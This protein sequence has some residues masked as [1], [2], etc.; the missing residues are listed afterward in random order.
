[1]LIALAD[2]DAAD[3]R[4]DDTI[5]DR[6]ARR[7]IRVLLDGAVVG[8]RIGGR[9][10]L[11]DA[12]RR[13]AERPLFTAAAALTLVNLGRLDNLDEIADLCTGRPGLAVRVAERVGSR[14]RELPDLIDGAHLHGVVRRLA[15]RGDLAGGL[16]AIAL[17]RPGATFEWAAP[18]RDL[19]LGL[20]AHTDADVR[21]E[22]Y[23]IDMS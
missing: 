12:V 6:P 23:S 14:V 11:I 17:I 9:V 16:F 1:V 19:L 8:A 4:P 15:V 2:R 22:A 7:R 21:E 20:R 5:A 18:W 3:E 10:A 13:L